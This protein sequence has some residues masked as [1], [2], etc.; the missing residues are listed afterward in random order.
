M[1]DNNRRPDGG[2][3]VRAPWRLSAFVLAMAVACGQALVAP[4]PALAVGRVLAARLLRA[5]RREVEARR[6][7]AAGAGL[8][9]NRFS[10]PSCTK[11]SS[12]VVTPLAVRN[13]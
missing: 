13:G 6:T 5:A 4:A 2:F 1:M 11:T 8:S 10:S 9:I 7:V 12:R 3:V